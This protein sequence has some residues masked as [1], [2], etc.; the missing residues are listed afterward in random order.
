MDLN[1]KVAFV[2]GAGQGLGWGIANAFALAGARVVVND[3]DDDLAVAAAAH[4]EA[5]GGMAA[6][7]RF[8]VADGPAFASAVA[9]T[10]ERWT[11]VDVVVHAAIFMPLV[12]F[13]A[14]DARTWRRQLDVGI[15][16]LFNAAKAVW[17]AMLRQGGGHVIGVASGSSLR[18]YTEEVAYC[19][20]KHGVEGFVKALA[21]E[22]EARGIAVNSMGPGAP[23]KPTRMGWDELNA[24]P[25][26]MTAQWADPVELGRAF[27]WLA[28]QPPTRFS[29]LRFDAGPIVA[30]LEHEG[31]S[32]TFEPEKVTAYPEDFRQRQDWRADYPR[33]EPPGPTS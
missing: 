3:I 19:T 4:I 18:G 33:T 16:G 6:A 7:A 10:L 23:I 14:L 24:L 26:D 1:G 12:T 29:G 15:G 13:E 17:P 27:V 32:F 2:T 8:D 25:S 11:R 5:A 21:L 9:S 28:S 20:V 22:A 31:A 30:T